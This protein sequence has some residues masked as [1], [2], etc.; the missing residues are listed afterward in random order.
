MNKVC[1]RWVP[2]L[3]TDE[4]KATRVDASREFLRR[5]VRDGERFL[6]RIITTDETWV[7]FYDLES[8]QESMVWK[9]PSSPPPKKAKPLQDGEESY[10]YF[11]HG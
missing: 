1:A 11:L 2:R 6:R 5:Y 3:L 4:N 10:V 9:R 8:K 7:N